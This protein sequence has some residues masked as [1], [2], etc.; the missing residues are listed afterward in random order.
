MNSSCHSTARILIVD[1][2]RSMREF[3]EIMLRKD[4]YVVQ[5]AEDGKCA[6]ELFQHEP[7]D[8]IIT[9]IRMK[10]VDGL[11]VLRRCKAI[12]PQ[13]VVIIISAYASA[14]TAVAAMKEGAYDYLPK[15]FKIEEMRAVI[16]N[17]L[18]SRSEEMRPRPVAEGPL[19]F[20]VLIG[21]SARMRKLYEMVERVAATNSS[22]LI[23]GESGTGKEL[24]ARAIHQKS[25]R[26]GAP[27]VTVNC[28]GV[29][30]TLI[31]SELFGYRKGAFTG[32]ASS[33]KG[34]V[35]T[36]N[37]GT[38]F[39]DE[40][41]ELSPALQVKL[42]R[43]IQERTIRM[44]G[45]TEDVAVDV[46]IISATNRDLEQMVIEG[47]FREDL[48][49]RLNV[50]H[51][52]MPPLRE[53][54][55]DIPRL[56]AHFLQKF[57]GKLGKDIRKISAYAMDILM[58]YNF[59][60]NIRELENIIER[61]IALESS[62]IVLPDSL[63]LS[64]HKKAQQ[65]AM[66]VPTSPTIGDGFNLDEHLAGIEKELLLRALENTQGVKLRAADLLGISFR[67]FRYRL[68][69]YGMAADDE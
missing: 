29:P 38:L 15:P 56:A 31:E 8:L 66:P 53:R 37:G 43:L 24:V 48:F 23:T 47:S 52:H 1:D 18:A 19:H 30:E 26:C 2:E 68:A 35:E 6:L 61:S 39:L 20:G 51:L 14:E 5:C 10:P 36:A 59:P 16:Q 32:A 4:G 22:V 65:F 25:P 57:R 69:K 9:D 34:L 42:L 45:G 67:S 11:E 28:G 12:A 58:N 50:I 13:T 33:R 27:L 46:R 62:S 55:E 63:T 21:E 49:Y 60:G 44:V 7:F 40:I 41:G 54:R 3:L 64:V 17:A